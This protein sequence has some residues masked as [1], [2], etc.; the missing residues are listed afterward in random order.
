MLLRQLCSWRLADP[1]AGR[2][3]RCSMRSGPR[4]HEHQHGSHCQA[5]QDFASGTC[6]IVLPDAAH[7]PPDMA[8]G[9]EGTQTAGN[10]TLWT[11]GGLR[12]IW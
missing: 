6:A 8:A 9:A 4:R 5:N 12:M 11:V 7:M 2:T 10:V 1:A 3:L